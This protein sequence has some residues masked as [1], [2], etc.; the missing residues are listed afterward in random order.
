MVRP[1]VHS[2]CIV[3]EQRRECGGGQPHRALIDIG[4]VETAEFQHLAFQDHGIRR[5]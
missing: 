1:L 3:G 4:I 5:Q 2:I